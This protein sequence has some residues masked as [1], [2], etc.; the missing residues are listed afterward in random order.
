MIDAQ[1]KEDDNRE[2][3]LKANYNAQLSAFSNLMGSM[4]GLFAE[5]TVA[6]KASATAKA[7]I[8]TYLAANEVFAQQQGGLPTRIAAMAATIAQ[9]LANVMAI[10]KTDTK[11][12]SVSNTTVAA[13]TATPQ[14]DNT[15]YTY[16]RTVQ[17]VASEEILNQSSEP[18]KVFV[19]ESDI[20]E[21]QNRVR[22][23]V[24]ES[25]W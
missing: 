15:P 24:L 16:A 22:A 6:Y 19:T 10:W 7:L 23:R 3:Q 4:E 13:A 12:P 25:E 9:G 11:N 8:D 17:T 18:I 20:T 21:T 5:N 2:K 14:V 1:K